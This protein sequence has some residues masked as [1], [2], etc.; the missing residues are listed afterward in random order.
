M[1]QATDEAPERTLVI[2]PS[3]GGWTVRDLARRIPASSYKTIREAEEEA[4]EYLALRGGGRL[5]VHREGKLVRDEAV[6]PRRG[7]RIRGQR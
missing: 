2:T 1:R 7:G 6:G 5:H 3:H 4:Q